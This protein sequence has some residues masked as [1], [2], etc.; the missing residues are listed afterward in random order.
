MQRQILALT[1]VEFPIAHIFLR[2]WISAAD[3]HF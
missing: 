1:R 3:R 2:N